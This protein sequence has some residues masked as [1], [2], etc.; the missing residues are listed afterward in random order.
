MKIDAVE[1]IVLR[2]D[3]VDAARADGGQ[4][5]LLV[6][7]Y[8]TDGVV[9]VGEVDSS[10]EVCKAVIDAPASHSITAGLRHLLVG[11]TVEDVPTT[12][13]MLYHGSIY[14]GRR[15]AGIHALSGVDMALWDIYGKVHG[16]PVSSFLGDNPRDSIRLYAS[17]LMEDTPEKVRATVREAKE[18]GF[19]ALKLGWGPIG[20]SRESDV[21]LMT[22]ARDEAGDDFDLMCDA[23][24]GYKGDV[25]EAAYI[26]SL[27]AD[28]G[29]G[30][31]EEAFFP[32]D[33]DAYTQ[34]T[35]KNILPIAAGEQ[36][37]T[38]WEFQELARA[39]ALNVWQPDIARCG[40]VTEMMNIAAIAEQHGVRVVPHAWKS[41]ILKAASLHV[42]AVLPGERIQEW[43]TAENPLAQELV[44]TPLP[45]VDGHAA[46][47]T[48]PGL[49]VEVDQAIVD[50]F[51]IVSSGKN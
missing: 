2:Q 30:W 16:K 5:S 24:Y 33:I 47:P 38:R 23:G 48:V 29:Y 6:R 26:A 31:L 8:T 1:A 22:A 46:V 11:Q 51:H 49:G 36:N 37:V 4:D 42:N 27:L 32:D 43:S 41:G 21:A 12:W 34:L 14:A 9:G 35:A 39:N 25:D 13:D 18:A 28:L 7:V 3:T 44:S 15:G 17:R 45:V 19:T 10:P 20:Q 40:G 50:R